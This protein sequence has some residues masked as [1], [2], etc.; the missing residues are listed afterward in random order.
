MF[1]LGHREL[2]DSDEAGT[3]RDLVSKCVA[4]LG[5]GEGETTL[6]QKKKAYVDLVKMKNPNV[7]FRR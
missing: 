3:G 4:N 2:A 1:D 5:R 6:H 7:K